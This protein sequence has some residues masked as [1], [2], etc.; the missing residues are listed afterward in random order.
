MSNSVTL[1]L[2][3]V[4]TGATVML[5]LMIP[6]H[7]TLVAAAGCA[8]MSLAGGVLAAHIDQQISR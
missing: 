5:P 1:F 3:G 2:L 8:T 4:G 6:D 7:W